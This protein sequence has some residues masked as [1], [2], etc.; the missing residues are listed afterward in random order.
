MSLTYTRYVQL[1]GDST[2]PS[3]QVESAIP[4][5]ERE[6]ERILRR[7]L[8]LDTY[9]HALPVH[10]GGR[11]YPKAVPI[12][13]LPASATFQLEDATTF[14]YVVRDSVSGPIG[15]ADIGEWFDGNAGACAMPELFGLA[16]VTYTGGWTETTM[17][18]AVARGLARL[19][20]AYAN[21][22]IQTE[23]IEGATS[24]SLGDASVSFKNPVSGDAIARLTASLESSLRGYGWLDGGLP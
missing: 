5:A 14:R 4:D 3:A 21:P 12:A 24:Q 11:A 10:E 13:S 1:T 23:L 18:M 7:P 16:T 20:H 9:T 8:W 19:V 15:P 17:P 2:T 6:M 22:T